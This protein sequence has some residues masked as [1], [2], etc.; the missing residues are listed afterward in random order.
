M[1]RGVVVFFNFKFV[2]DNVHDVFNSI[3]RSGLAFH[4]VFDV[5]LFWEYLSLG[6]LKWRTYS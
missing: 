2:K 1:E 4:K 5:G 6:I 3:K